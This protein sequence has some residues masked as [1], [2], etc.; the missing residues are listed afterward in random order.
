M[1]CG[2]IWEEEGKLCVRNTSDDHKC[3]KHDG[4]GDRVGWG[5]GERRTPVRLGEEKRKW[6]GEIE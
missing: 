3:P 2:E 4:D 6:K 1:G 5:V